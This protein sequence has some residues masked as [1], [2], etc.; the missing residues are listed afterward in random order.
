MM[1]RPR[2]TWAWVVPSTSFQQAQSTS[3]FSRARSHS[4]EPRPPWAYLSCAMLKTILYQSDMGASGR[5]RASW[6][7]RLKKSA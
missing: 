1:S 3:A 6:T 4:Q 7:A 5:G 2:T